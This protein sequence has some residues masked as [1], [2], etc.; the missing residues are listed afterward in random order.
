MASRA[1]SASAG[2]RVAVNLGGVE[3]ADVSRGDTLCVRRRDSG[4]RV[5]VDA[6]VDML[7]G[8][9]PLRHGMRVRFHQGTT[10]LLGRVSVRAGVGRRQPRDDAGR[11]R[12]V[13]WRVPIEIAAGGTRLR[14]RAPRIAGGP[15]AR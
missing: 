15:D 4:A 6:R 8:A 11:R 14:S 9:P 2:E 10:E 1:A 3:L 5:R 12:R 7:P 13:S